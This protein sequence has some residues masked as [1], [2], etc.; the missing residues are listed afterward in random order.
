MINNQIAP[1][2]L[3]IIRDFL[4]TWEIP[5][6]T[7]TPTDRLNTQKDVEDFIFKHFEDIHFS[8][9]LEILHQF[10]KDLRISIELNTTDSLNKWLTQYPIEISI[11]NPENI[12]YNSLNKQEFFSEILIIVIESIAQNQWKRLKSCPDCR[13]V[14]YDNSRN[15]S[16]RWCGMYAS[17]PKGR[18]CGTIAKVKRHR[19]K[20]KIQ[21]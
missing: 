13:W 18:S 4:N 17:E 7:R 3:E 21:I 10:R 15:A 9:D 20:N 11:V 16:K 2:R 8:R 12:Q 6:D 1:G 14:F 5:N 19:K